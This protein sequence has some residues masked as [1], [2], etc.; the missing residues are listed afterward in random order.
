MLRGTFV[1]VET[2]RVQYKRLQREYDETRGV[3][4]VQPNKRLNQERL[5]KLHE[6]GFAWSAKH[7]R[8]QRNNSLQNTGQ[9]PVAENPQGF[10]PPDPT[11]VGMM[12]PVGPS[13]PV[14]TGLMDAVMPSIP[15]VVRPR[16]TEPRPAG[17]LNDQQWEE[18]YQ[19]LVRYKEDYGDCLVP[20]KYERDPKLSTWVETQRVRCLQCR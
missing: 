7:V 3:E 17:R 2:Q 19:R 9:P 13:V 14:P 11:A 10:H 20:R 15:T 16:K 18:M 6:I 4:S 12:I 8:K 1:Q 5:R